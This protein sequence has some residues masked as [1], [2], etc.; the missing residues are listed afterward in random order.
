M[1]YKLKRQQ[2]K[3]KPSFVAY[4]LGISTQCY[5]EV[6]NGRRGLSSD[7]VEVFSDLVKNKNVYLMEQNQLIK[8]TNEW[9][10]KVDLD[11][12]IK[13]FGYSSGYK[14]A[15]AMGVSYTK[16]W[17]V[18]KKHYNRVSDDGILDIYL[19]LH[20]ENNRFY[21]KKKDEGEELM[22]L[23]DDLKVSHTENYLN[24][25]D[26]VQPT[27]TKYDYVEPGIVN[28]PSTWIDDKMNT[29][30]LPTVISYPDIEEYKTR[31]EELKK[32]N[33]ELSEKLANQYKDLKLYRIRCEAYESIFL[34]EE[35]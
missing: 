2:C 31:I 25:H 24:Q 1:N 29:G 32:E 35:N 27:T 3:F 18:M 30:E 15:Q 21:E 34:R 6:E 13:K 12:E 23:V 17:D 8:E 19:F 22:E 9:L 28:I 16:I 20:D 10:K 7:K 14:F 33:E 5:K 26:T 4:K 11:E